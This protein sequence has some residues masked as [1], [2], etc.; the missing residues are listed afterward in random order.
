M[1][2]L[3]MSRGSTRKMSASSGGNEAVVWN[4][5]SYQVPEIVGSNYTT[6][7]RTSFTTQQCSPFQEK[8]D[9]AQQNSET[10]V[11]ALKKFV[12]SMHKCDLPRKICRLY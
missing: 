8:E 9:T 4:R 6:K 10:C 3:R 7:K 11:D 12:V 1:N 5:C 2:N